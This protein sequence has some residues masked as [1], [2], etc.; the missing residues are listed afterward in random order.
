MG[1]LRLDATE[2][3]AR[4]QRVL[5]GADAL[6][7]LRWPTIS[8]VDLPGS[9]VGRACSGS[10]LEDRLADV[11]TGMRTWAA[12]AQAATVAVEQSDLRQSARL[13]APR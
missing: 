11:V 8:S 13:G 10:G 5:D 6:D 2:V 3:R 9:A 7:E 4:A 12:T 1:T